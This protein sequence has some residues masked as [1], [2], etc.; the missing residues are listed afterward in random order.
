MSSKIQNNYGQI[1]RRMV[2][3][4]NVVVVVGLDNDLMYVQPCGQ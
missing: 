2:E 4:G 1:R 3:W